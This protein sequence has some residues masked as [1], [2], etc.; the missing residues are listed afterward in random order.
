MMRG[1]KLILFA[2]LIYF[3][4]LPQS[5]GNGALSADT[6]RDFARAHELLDQGK[7]SLAL[8]SFTD[9]RRRYP[10]DLRAAEAQYRIGEIY[11]KQRKYSEA[12]AELRKVF[13]LKD[14]SARKAGLRA[15]L[16]LGQAFLKSQQAPLARIEW[17]AVLRRAPDS[18]E[19][20]EAKNFLLGLDPEAGH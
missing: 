13:E 12:I 14:D 6:Q 19:A 3:A 5:W 2:G 4:V 15:S 1:R 10:N 11:F 20:K 7:E 18:T 9:F 8:V 16:L 17:E